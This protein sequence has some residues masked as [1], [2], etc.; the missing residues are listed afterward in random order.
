MIAIPDTVQGA[1]TISIIDFILS[2]VIISGIGV[3]LAIL[4]VVNR[5]WKIDEAKL[6]QGH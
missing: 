5:R 2:F 6:K 1:V 3:L 4:P